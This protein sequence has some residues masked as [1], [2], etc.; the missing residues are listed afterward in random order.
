VKQGTAAAYRKVAGAVEA[1][2]LMGEQKHAATSAK[3]AA[4]SADPTK[5]ARFMSAAVVNAAAAEGLVVHAYKAAPLRQV[6]FRHE[7][8]T[9]TMGQNDG[10]TAYGKSAE[11]FIQPGIDENIEL[12][13]GPLDVYDSGTVAY[14][15]G[16]KMPQTLRN[17]EEND[18]LAGGDDNGM[19][20]F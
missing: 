1:T 18:A 19:G 3:S 20:E 12:D 9:Q 2:A 14:R 16:G 10:Q 6:D 13:S 11:Q 17:H 4:P 15:G 7:E 5:I 8:S